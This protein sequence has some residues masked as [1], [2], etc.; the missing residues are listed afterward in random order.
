ME[1]VQR[2]P[3]QVQRGSVP[4]LLARKWRFA[5]LGGA[6]LSAFLAS[7]CCLG[8]LVFALLGIG[9]AGLL[10][11]FAAYRPYLSALTLG[12]LGLGFFFTYRPT[13]IAKAATVE[14]AA[15]CDC[16]HPRSSRLGKVMLW[17]ATAVV[18]AFL[19]FP[20]VAPYLF[21]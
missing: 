4:Q 1:E 5:S 10:V 7:L 20:Y 15:E 14:G 9:G 18:L 8:P 16:E 17:I 13:R 3:V 19:G 2:V 12:L 6:V 11:K 21:Q